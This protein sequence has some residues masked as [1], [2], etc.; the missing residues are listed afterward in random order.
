MVIVEA[1][2]QARV[3]VQRPWRNDRP[4]DTS[5]QPWLGH[6]AVDVTEAQRGRLAAPMGLFSLVYIGV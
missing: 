3:D 1:I 5:F 4:L 2:G 6:L